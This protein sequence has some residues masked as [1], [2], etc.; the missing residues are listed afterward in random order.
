MYIGGGV[1]PIPG[2]LVH[3]IQD[4]HFIDMAML[5][6]D[7]LE[8]ANAA[9]ED[10]PKD[11]GGKLQPVTHILDRIQCFSTYIAVVSCTKPER[12]VDLVGYLNLIVKGPKEFSRP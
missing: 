12:V 3:R 9:D 10:Q 2:K 8:A 4:G 11:N 5:L 7:N 1:P 6:N